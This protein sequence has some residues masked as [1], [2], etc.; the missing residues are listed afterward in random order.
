MNENAPPDHKATVVVIDDDIH[1]LELAGLILSRRGYQ[2]LTAPTAS[3]GMEIISAQLPELVLLDYMMPE[4]DGLSAL[5]EIRT[6]FP[7][8]Y[9]V[10]FTGK[11][12]E[13]I[14]VD[15]MKGGASEYILKP[16]NNRDLVE[17]LVLFSRTRLLEAGAVDLTALLA[18]LAPLL[19]EALGEDHGAVVLAAALAG[20]DQLDDPIDEPVEQELGVGRR[21]QTAVQ[22]CTHGL[23]RF[24]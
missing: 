16:F 3:V 8:T 21:G 11:G 9:V 19:R 17:R 1:I 20:E 2:V 4:M 6:R 15:L 12:S 18:R 14:A 7:D 22:S 10:M 5:H 23:E 24:G 13:Q